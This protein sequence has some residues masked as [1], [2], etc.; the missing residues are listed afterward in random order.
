M[1]ILPVSEETIG[2]LIHVMEWAEK[3]L[4]PPGPKRPH[5]YG[6]AAKTAAERLG[7][8]RFDYCERS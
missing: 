8:E 6:E 7:Y 4:S 3:H 1:T 5:E 2:D